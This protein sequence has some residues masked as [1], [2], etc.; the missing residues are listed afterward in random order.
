MSGAG[1]GPPPP[2]PATAASPNAVPATP[3]ATSVPSAPGASAVPTPPGTS[4]RTGCQTCPATGLCDCAKLTLIASGV[5][6]E[7]HFPT[8]T[9]REISTTRSLRFGPLTLRLQD[10]HSEI[11]DYTSY[12]L[13]VACVAGF[14]DRDQEPPLGMRRGLIAKT[15]WGP[16]CSNGRE[17]QIVLDAVR[18]RLPGFPVRGVTE[19]RS[20][21]PVFAQENNL[22][23]AAINGDSLAGVLFAAVSAA[24]GEDAESVRRFEV[25][26]QSCGVRPGGASPNGSLRGLFIIYR[27]MKVELELTLAPPAQF[28]RVRGRAAMNWGPGSN[29][30]GFRL[31]TDLV[32]YAIP[33][34]QSHSELRLPE[35]P[36]RENLS[37]ERRRQLN[38]PVRESR[39]AT[40]GQ[41][42]RFSLK[43]NDRVHNATRWVHRILRVKQQVEDV[44]DGL[45]DLVDKAPQL[46]WRWEYQAEVLTGQVALEYERKE[47][48]GVVDGRILPA[49]RQLSLRA[50]LL[51]IKLEGT[52]SF[53]WHFECSLGYAT[54]R[55]G[56]TFGGEARTSVNFRLPSMER[57]R[58]Q[59]EATISARVFGEAALVR[60]ARG[61]RPESRLASA[62]ATA[63]TGIVVTWTIFDSNPDGRRAGGTP[64]NPWVN[65]IEIKR[66]A[67]E[68]EVRIEEAVT[69]V[70][71]FTRRYTVW[72][73]LV[74]YPTT[75]Q[76]PAAQPPAGG[77][78]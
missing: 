3:P 24:M 38:E 18:Q 73:E 26:A 23:S 10:V 37:E 77:G 64:R 25:V 49:T 21:R 56:V 31:N 62:R 8:G 43:I 54:A 74:L 70:F 57:R 12:D 30:A 75:N 58:W 61:D 50:E 27:R 39:Q 40:L 34:G 29:P 47:E 60:A 51:L 17:H 66:K 46:G 72:P 63:S 52:L 71:S 36:P 53:G 19:V 55:L 5:D 20:P 16:T 67:V 4:L 59:G 9:P 7:E 69:G 45:A 78:R 1:G 22:D 2:R 41:G 35:T 13:I 6:D 14:T 68:A 33:E 32:R 44:L 76:A 65:E 42:S 15:E 11:E 48:T 28:R